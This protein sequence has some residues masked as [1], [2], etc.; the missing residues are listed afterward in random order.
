MVKCSTIYIRTST[1]KSP[2]LDFVL[3]V[4]KSYLSEEYFSPTV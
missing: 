1:T 4:R 2:V 3:Q